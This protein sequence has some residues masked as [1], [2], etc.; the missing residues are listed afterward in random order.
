MCIFEGYLKERKKL[1]TLNLVK[2]NLSEKLMKATLWFAK[3][4]TD[5]ICT[6]LTENA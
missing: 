5:A 2:L 6:M 4:N 3:D 1:L